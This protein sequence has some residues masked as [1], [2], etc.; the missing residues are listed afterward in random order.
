MVH[1]AA[2]SGL[3]DTTKVTLQGTGVFSG[4][5][6]DVLTALRTVMRA[7]TL[8]AGTIVFS[9]GDPGDSSIIIRRGLIRL[10]RNR[11]ESQIQLGMRGPGDMVGET[12]L[13]DDSSRL[14]TAVC[15]TD[16]RVFELPRTEFYRIIVTYPQ[17]AQHVM[18]ILTARIRESDLSRLR[19]LEEQREALERRLLHQE[20]LSIKGEMAAEISHDLRNFLLMLQGH[21]E[22][23]EAC[24]ERGAV[25]R[26]G[27]YMKG[28]HSAIDQ[29]TV[30]AESL[31]HCQ[32]PSNRRR[33]F[34]LNEFIR[35][36][37][38]FLGPLEQLRGVSIEAQLQAQ[39]PPI[40]SDP[41]MLQQVIYC[42]LLNA[43]EA[44]RD[45]AIPK[46][47]VVV[48]TEYGRAESVFCLR[49]A[50]NGPG[51]P[52]ETLPHLFK[53][54]VSTKDTGHGY[55]LLNAARCTAELG[56]A[57]AAR[58]RVSAGAEFTVTLPG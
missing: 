54:R 17:I 7:K 6:S 36:Q 9:E 43:A 5:P 24:L 41:A 23:V 56:G 32:H 51:I 35:Q 57:I 55:G 3:T 14:T 2:H 21:V 39:L 27:H 50:D 22:L 11:G 28:I 19:D 15:E 47:T 49:I 46:P 31:L 37:I 42:L 25:D 58:N 16:C 1:P 40:V 29:I 8:V 33:S 44:M 12:A 20:R 38:T 52:A 30:F 18:R 13:L 45:A 34:D 26:V 10:V 53:D 48:R 4:M